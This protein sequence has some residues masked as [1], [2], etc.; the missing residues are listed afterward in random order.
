MGR[1]DERGPLSGS[2]PKSGPV[3][4]IFFSPAR[5]GRKR[6]MDGGDVGVDVV[7]LGKAEAHVLE[8][9]AGEAQRPDGDLVG[10][11]G[12]DGHCQ[13]EGGAVIVEV[14]VHAVF[15][16]LGGKAV[17]LDVIPMDVVE[18]DLRAG[19]L[20]GDSDGMGVLV[21]DGFRVGVEVVH[22]RLPVVDIGGFE[23]GVGPQIVDRQLILL[24]RPPLEHMGDDGEGAEGALGSPAEALQ[25]HEL[26]RVAVGGLPS[27]EEASRVGE[28]LGEPVFDLEH[29][30][31]PMP[32]G[33]HPHGA[34][35]HLPHQIPL[36]RVLRDLLIGG[37]QGVVHAVDG[38]AARLQRR[39]RH[40]GEEV[41][42][43]GVGVEGLHALGGQHRVHYVVFYGIDGI[44]E[45][46][47]E[48]AAVRIPP[49]AGPNDGVIL[50]A[51]PGEDVPGGPLPAVQLFLNPGLVHPVQVQQP[52]ALLSRPFG[53]AE[54]VGGQTAHLAA[55]RRGGAHLVPPFLR[56]G[57][58]PGLQRVRGLA[59]FIRAVGLHAL[60][61]KQRF[62]Y[63][64]PDSA[65]GVPVFIFGGVRLFP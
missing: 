59:V 3:Y 44:P 7:A 31:H 41:G 16:G 60:S 1:P 14:V 9:A 6:S 15:V 64:R 28:H 58:Q 10:G 22:Q 47:A 5:T 54:H 38:V 25:R 49:V 37:D 29:G 24:V 61:G 40:V 11:E 20:I 52:A 2:I 12:V 13:V 39:L 50:T 8:A 27:A 55:Q 57:H 18:L 23:G 46:V 42:R 30:F 32:P 19:P 4:N 62:F 63:E 17:L 33:E 34:A 35:V 43:G 56:Q 36:L 51:A 48:V 21:H 26:G 65:M 45:L 53:V